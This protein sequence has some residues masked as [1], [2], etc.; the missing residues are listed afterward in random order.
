MEQRHQ[1]TFETYEQG[2]LT[3][4]EYLS[5]VVFH[6]R[7]PFTRSAVPALHVR[8]IASRTPR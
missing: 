3:L 7:R 4:D 1:L 8:A 2:K 5:L 6:E